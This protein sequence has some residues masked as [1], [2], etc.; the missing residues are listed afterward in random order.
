MKN[1]NEMFLGFIVVGLIA[2]FSLSAQAN[3]YIDYDDGSSFTVPEGAKVYVSN[4][5]IFTKRQYA[6]GSVFFE[7]IAPNTKRDQAAPSNTGVTPGSHEWCVAWVP[8]AN[9]FTFGQMTWDSQCD[10][11]DDGVYNELD[12]GWEG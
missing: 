2:L 1:F 9:G 5:I 4:E 8:W 11:N 3:T 6:N 12:E 7:P 10:T